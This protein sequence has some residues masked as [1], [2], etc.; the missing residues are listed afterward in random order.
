MKTRHHRIPKRAELL[1]EKIGKTEEG[2]ACILRIYSDTS[3][4]GYPRRWLFVY[5][6]DW[7]RSVVKLFTGKNLT[8]CWEWWDANKG[9]IL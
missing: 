4:D 9:M 8:V 2:K 6:E 1:K 5:R 3:A 7:D